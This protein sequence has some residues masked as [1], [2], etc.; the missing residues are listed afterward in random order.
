MGSYIN[1]DLSISGSATLQNKL[2]VNGA[3]TLGSTLEV[4]GATELQQT[5]SVKGNVFVDFDSVINASSHGQHRI[6]S[7]KINDK[8]ITTD[9][10]TLQIN[11]S[12]TFE[13]NVYM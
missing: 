3:T 4:F 12:S 10:N 1:N 5:L 13:Q 6:G 9:D 7:L 11:A 8:T 2:S